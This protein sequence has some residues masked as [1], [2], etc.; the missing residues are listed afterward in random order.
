MLPTRCRSPNHP[1]APK[2]WL[3]IVHPNVYL[4]RPSV[5]VLPVV[6]GVEGIYGQTRVAAVYCNQD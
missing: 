4:Q 3:F 2:G 1:E 5:L 6:G